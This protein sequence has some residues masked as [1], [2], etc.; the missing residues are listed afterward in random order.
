MALNEEDCDSIPKPTSTEACKHPLP[1]CPSLW[2]TG[3]W[4]EVRYDFRLFNPVT[5]AYFILFYTSA[6]HNCLLHVSVFIG[7]YF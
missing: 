2:R 1:A 5:A 4:S 6:F 3:P 7:L